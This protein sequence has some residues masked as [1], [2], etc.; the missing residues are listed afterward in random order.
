MTSPSWFAAIVDPG[1]E[2]HAE[3]EAAIVTVRR[4]D[5]WS[6]KVQTTLVSSQVGVKTPP[7]T[8]P[9]AS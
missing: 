4:R 2:L 5:R 8:K 9:A 1:D 7:G 6:P 3:V